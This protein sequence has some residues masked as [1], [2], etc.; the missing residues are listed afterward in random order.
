MSDQPHPF[1]LEIEAIERAA[2]ADLAAVAPPAVAQAIGLQTAAIGA[3][4]FFMATRIA[5]LQFNW[6]SGAGLNGDDG[7]SI[8]EAVRRFRAAGQREFIIQL[9]PGPNLDACI[10]RA[11]AAGLVEHPLA[12][13]KF[14]RTTAHAPE[15]NTPLTIREVGPEERDLFAATAIAG[16]GMPSPM[17][18][19]LAQLTG[20]PHW[21]TYVTLAGAEPA[22]AAASYVRGDHAWLGIGATRPQMR[23][24]GSQSALL[25]RRLADAARLG[26]RHATT[27]TGAPQPGQ[28]APSYANILKA[29]FEVAY[30]RRNWSEPP[31]QDAAGS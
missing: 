11:A 29:G 7:H 25:A 18:A 19:W 16:F 14:H 17:A 3:A 12:W 8:S 27:E 4:F 10:A 1:M 28:P 30:V 2:W 13:A 5:Q 6:L 21:H 15:I 31:P 23:K 22:G 24:R 9:P 26:A 20:R